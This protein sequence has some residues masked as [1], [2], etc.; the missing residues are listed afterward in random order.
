MVEE[1]AK[2][3]KNLQFLESKRNDTLFIDV[4]PTELWKRI[5]KNLDYVSL[6]FAKQTCKR[7][8]E[9]VDVFD[10]VQ[11]A[12]GKLLKFCNSSRK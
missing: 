6:G 4:L 3:M 7:W 12:S 1:F 8:N 11:L 2:E 5:L 9:I 10:L